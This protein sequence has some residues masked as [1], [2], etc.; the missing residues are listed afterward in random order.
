MKTI[1][2]LI[3]E[4]KQRGSSRGY[5]TYDEINKFLP[6]NPIFLDKIDDI[7]NELKDS[8]LEIVDETM[9][10]GIRKSKSIRKVKATPL[11]IRY[12]DDPVRMYLKDIG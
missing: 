2:Q 11:K 3:G 8:G 4:L 10:G 5:V 12:F 1:S 6:D 9:K 7:F